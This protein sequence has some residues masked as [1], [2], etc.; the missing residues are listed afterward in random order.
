MTKLRVFGKKKVRCKLLLYVRN[1]KGD[2]CSERMEKNK[3]INKQKTE[4]RLHQDQHFPSENAERKKKGEK[5]KERERKRKER[6]RESRHRE[7]ISREVPSYRFRG[8]DLYNS[9]CPRSPKLKMVIKMFPEKTY[10]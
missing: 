1:P 4:E 7:L 10:E 8:S 5:E 6:E 9:P 3:L 2:I